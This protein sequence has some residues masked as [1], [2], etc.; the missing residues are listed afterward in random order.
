MEIIEAVRTRKSIRS[1]KPI[2]YQG[3]PE[4]D[5]GG[6]YQKPFV[7]KY[8]TMGIRCNHRRSI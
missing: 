3:N 2:P 6:C 5:L 4:A 7:T 8:T 1:Y